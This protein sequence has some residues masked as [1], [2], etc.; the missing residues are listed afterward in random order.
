MDVASTVLW[1]LRVYGVAGLVAALPFLTVGVGRVVPGARGS[2]PPFRLTILPGVVVLW[3]VVL[4]R[5]IGALR[6]GR[7]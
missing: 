6:G 3:P 7:R 4:V 1:V 2:G 5:W